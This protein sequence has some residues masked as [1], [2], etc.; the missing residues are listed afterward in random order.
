[1]RAIQAQT[2]DLDEALESFEKKKK[3]DWTVEEQW[4]DHKALSLIQLH[5]SNDILQEVMQE[6]SAIEL[7][8]KL[9]SIYISKDLTSKMH[10]KMKLFMHMMQDGSVL[11]HISVFKE[12]VADLV[13]MEVKFDD[14]DLGLLLLCS[15][16]SSYANFRDTILLSRDELTL[17]E[18]YEALQSREKMKGMVQSEASSSKG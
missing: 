15:M 3:D 5:I 18:V 7:W 8:L 6:K 1:M 14:E 16:P 17:S 9:E 11:N 2:L 10:M 13:S 12:I 4:K